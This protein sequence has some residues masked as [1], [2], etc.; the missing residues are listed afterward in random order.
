[1]T[2]KSSYWLCLFE[3]IEYKNSRCLKIDR[4]VKTIVCIAYNLF[5]DEK[6]K[7]YYWFI[8]KFYVFI[9]FL[10]QIFSCL[11]K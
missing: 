10:W 3:T 1:M 11:V 9:A 6:R 5:Y 4:S 2:F 7:H 8:S